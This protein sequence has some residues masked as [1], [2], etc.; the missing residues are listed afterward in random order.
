MP[1]PI[2]IWRLARAYRYVH[3]NHKI[4]REHRLKYRDSYEILARMFDYRQGGMRYHA[5]MQR[6]A[7]EQPG[8]GVSREAYHRKIMSRYGYLTKKAMEARGLETPKGLDP[9]PEPV[10][11]VRI[12]CDERG[13]YGFLDDDWGG[14]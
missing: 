4:S 5:A 12:S 3:K 6:A 8:V 10:V 13:Q 2:D 9:I 14:T 1:V 11:P 7:H